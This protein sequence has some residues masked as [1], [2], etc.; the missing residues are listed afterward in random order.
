M[1]AYIVTYAV[2]DAR[3]NHHPVSIPSRGRRGF[4]FLDVD[5]RQSRAAPQVY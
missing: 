4:D 5:G 1:F 3:T 2:V